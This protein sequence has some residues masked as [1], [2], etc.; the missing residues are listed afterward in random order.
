M[1]TG[2]TDGFEEVI[3]GIFWGASEYSLKVLG[4]DIEA[5][6]GLHYLSGGIEHL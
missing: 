4:S 3:Q 1:E 5:K 2:S 6:Q